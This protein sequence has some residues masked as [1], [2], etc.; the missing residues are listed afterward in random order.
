MVLGVRVA[1]SQQRRVIAH[2][3]GV[4][5][6]KMFCARRLAV[7]P[8]CVCFEGGVEFL[9]HIFFHCS[10]VRPLCELVESYMVRILGGRFFCP[11][12]Q[13]RLRQCCAATEEE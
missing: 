5:E 13:V 9:G 6:G 12:G 3:A 2:L 10:F 7:T 8:P 11:R 4:A 1:V